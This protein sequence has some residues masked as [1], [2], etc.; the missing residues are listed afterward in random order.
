VFAQIRHEGAWNVHPGG[1]AK[2]LRQLRQNTALRVSLK[3]TPVTP[4][5]DDLTPF[6]FLYLTGLDDFEFDEQAVSA[7]RRFLN[8]GGTLF[9]NNGLGLTTFDRAVVRELGKV[10][11][12]AG[13]APVPPEHPLFSSV[14]RIDSA[15]YT[16]AVANVKPDLA[17]PFLEGISINGDLRVIYS[18]FD[19]EA[20]WQGYEYPLAKAYEPDSGTQL[21]VNLIM[22]AMTH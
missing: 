15:R 17:F 18:P 5:V 2:L 6:T 12:D 11:P 9:V 14:F 10:L 20:A 3:R 8:N 1:A 19:M 7:L 21:G 4:G 16:P 13:L 22:Y